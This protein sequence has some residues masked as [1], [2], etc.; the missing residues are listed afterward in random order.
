M[1]NIVLHDDAFDELR[2]SALDSGRLEPFAKSG[3]SDEIDENRFIIGGVI[4]Q[5]YQYVL[6]PEDI[7]RRK[8]FEATPL[9][10]MMKASFERYA[11]YQVEHLLERNVL[12]DYLN[13]DAKNNWQWPD[14][15]LPR[16]LKIRLPE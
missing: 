3:T 6:T 8:E 7:A 16:T 14:S 9:G 1:D 4:F 5:R 12:L 10:Q 15:I 2:A 13:G 11:K